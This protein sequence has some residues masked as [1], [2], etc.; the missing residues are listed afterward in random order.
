M[1]SISAIS[2]HHHHHASPSQR[3]QDELQSEVSSGT[4]SATD[5]SA[6]SAAINDISSSLQSNGSGDQSS[7]SGSGGIKS[8]IDDLIKQEVSSGKLS[9]QQATELQGIFK[10]AFSH[11]PGGPDSAGG[12]PPSD[13]SSQV[14]GTDNSAVDMLQ[15]FLQALKSSLTDSTY[16]GTGSSGSSNPA[17]PSLSGVLLNDRI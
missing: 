1:T 11:G 17:D 13:G 4:I 12:P 16:S 6:L 3:L 2:T 9:D 7:A 14:D 8:K 15:Q 10:T 5:Q